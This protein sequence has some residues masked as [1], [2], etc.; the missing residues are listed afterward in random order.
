MKTGGRMRTGGRQWAF[1]AIVGFLPCFVKPLF[2]GLLGAVS[3]EGMG[4]ILEIPDVWLLTWF[5]GF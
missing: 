3:M 2:I 4:W 1:W 5:L